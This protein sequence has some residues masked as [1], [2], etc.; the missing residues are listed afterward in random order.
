VERSCDLYPGV[1]NSLSGKIEDNEVGV[2]VMREG[3]EGK[4]IDG[5]TL[6]Y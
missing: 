2:G 4:E 3:K 1:V 5:K 6:R